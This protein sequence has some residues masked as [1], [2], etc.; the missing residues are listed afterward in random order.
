MKGVNYIRRKYCNNE[1][2]KKNEISGLE[3]KWD[4]INL[5]RNI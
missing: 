3:E 4:R 1:F 2:K 5:L